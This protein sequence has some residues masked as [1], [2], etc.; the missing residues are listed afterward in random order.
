MLNAANSARL[1]Y[2]YEMDD[3]HQWLPGKKEYTH[4]VIA[5][6]GLRKSDFYNSERL[7]GITPVAQG[8]GPQWYEGE[9][10]VS[11]FSIYSSAQVGIFGSIIR[12]TDIEYI[13]QLNC[14]ATD[15]CGSNTY[16]TYLYYNPYNISK[17]ITFKNVGQGAVDLY[18]AVNH[19][20]V[21]KNI[22]TETKFEIP[23]DQARLIVVLPHNSSVEKKN[24]RYYVGMNIVAYQ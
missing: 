15:F 16:P 20:V 23:A 12:T 1:Y 5:Y 19:Q 9:P 21:A 17:S 24:N 22:I 18:D 11:M 2:P 3:N 4:G 6:E 13:L 7:K 14:N 10:D 8:D